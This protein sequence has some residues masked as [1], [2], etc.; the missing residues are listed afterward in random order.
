MFAILVLSAMTLG[1]KK[2]SAD[3][4]LVASRWDLNAKSCTLT[5]YRW[6]AQK[7]LTVASKVNSIDLPIG[8]PLLFAE[9]TT[10][11][12]V[13]GNR[14]GTAGVVFFSDL[15]APTFIVRPKD[16]YG[17]EFSP[18]GR[19][20][21]LQG[22]RQT[23][24]ERD[25]KSKRPPNTS[26]PRG[27]WGTKLDPNGSYF[28]ARDDSVPTTLSTP[29]F[30]TTVV[31]MNS[32]KI[33]TIEGWLATVRGSEAVFVGSDHQPFEVNLQTGQRIKDLAEEANLKALLRARLS[34]MVWGR[35]SPTW[36]ELPS[37]RSSL[38]KEFCISGDAKW[39]V[40]MTNDWPG[41]PNG[42]GAVDDSNNYVEDA[43]FGLKGGI[44]WRIKRGRFF[45]PLGFQFTDEQ[46]TFEFAIQAPF[47]MGAKALHSYGPG[48]YRVEPL[49]G[50]VKKVQEI[51]P[52]LNYHQTGEFVDAVMV[53][54]RK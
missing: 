24:S 34:N 40:Q 54:S 36:M 42:E 21:L 47:W 6:Q 39:M 38:K 43:V 37:S 11:G 48:I 26:Q 25:R 50:R 30:S 52:A 3:Y 13:S 46:G 45:S 7:W 29:H 44:R 8:E 53:A 9:S 4:E 17:L 31:R 12:A 10:A 23:A 18:D 33:L 14:A 5:R 27:A 15:A 1:S 2:A 19:F 20:L 35:G 22:Y 32:L 51:P 41:S 49:K 28:F 16:M